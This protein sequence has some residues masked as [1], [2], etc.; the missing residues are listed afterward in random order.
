MGCDIHPYIEVLGAEIG[1]VDFAEVYLYPDYL[2]FALLADVRN[3]FGVKPIVE[4]RGFPDD[5]GWT[6]CDG[7]KEWC[8]VSKTF[9]PSPG[10]HSASYL[11]LDELRLVLSEHILRSEPEREIKL[12]IGNSR[13]V[14]IIKAMEE[15]K[16]IGEPRLVFFFDN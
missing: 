11:Y 4:P 7:Y 5:A 14:A 6:A 15:L 10:H 16:H 9:I 2:L 13:F 12:G 3:D 8:D 1:P